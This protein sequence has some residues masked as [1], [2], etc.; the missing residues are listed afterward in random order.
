MGKWVKGE[1]GS[2]WVSIKRFGW[3]FFLI[4]ERLKAAEKLVKGA[5]K[6]QQQFREWLDGQH[7]IE[8]RQKRKNGLK[9][10]LDS[11]SKK[12]KY[13]D[14]IWLKIAELVIFSYLFSKAFVKFKICSSWYLSILLMKSSQRIFK[15]CH[16]FL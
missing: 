1:T 9:N 2:C 5:N 8:L 16:I 10:E 6:L 12:R 7:K 13:L 3:L 11:V 14:Q 4:T 15:N